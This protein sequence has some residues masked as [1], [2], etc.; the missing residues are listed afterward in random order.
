MLIFIINIRGIISLAG[1]IANYAN[2]VAQISGE[3]EFTALRGISITF[4]FIGSEN[5]IGAGYYFIYK[6]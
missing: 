2:K 3:I 1:R 6:H 5:G 4:L